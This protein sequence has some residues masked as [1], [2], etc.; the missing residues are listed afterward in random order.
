MGDSDRGA[1][2]DQGEFLR[3]VRGRP[4]EEELA[5]LMAVLLV[6]RTGGA[7]ADEEA[8]GPSND[9][10]WWRGPDEEAAARAPR[11]PR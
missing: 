5:G 1:P 8:A 10:G 7:K 2:G 3:I 4:G 9:S 6:L 11:G